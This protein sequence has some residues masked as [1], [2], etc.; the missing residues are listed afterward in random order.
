MKNPA[1]N[2]ILFSI[3][4]LVMVAGISAPAVANAQYT[5]GPEYSTYSGSGYGYQ[6]YPT[7]YYPD[8]GSQYYQY[9]SYFGQTYYPTTPQYYSYAPDLNYFGPQYYYPTYPQPQQY[10]TPPQYPHY[11]P[12]QYPDYD[13]HYY[14]DDYEPLR[15]TCKP[16]TYNADVNEYVTWTAKATGGSGSYKYAW[17]GERMDDNDDERQVT[18]RYRDEGYKSPSVTV[19]SGGQRITKAC[20]VITVED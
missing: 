18:V 19:K 4:A 11:P 9:P 14:D 13:D 8:Y 17:V 7:S 5:Y 2:I 15:V 12:Y 1:L 20:P 10:Y 6:Y 16:S 3:L